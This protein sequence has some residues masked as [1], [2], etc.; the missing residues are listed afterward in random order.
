MG[1]F[2]TTPALNPTN[3]IIDQEARRVEKAQRRAAERISNRVESH[4]AEIDISWTLLRLRSIGG[5]AA[6]EVIADIAKK[7]LYPEELKEAINALAALEAGRKIYDIVV[8][9][10][11]RNAEIVNYAIAA[12]GG[13]S[14]RHIY[15]FSTSSGYVTPC[16]ELSRFAEMNA[17]AGAPQSIALLKGMDFSL[18]GEFLCNIAKKFPERHGSEIIEHLAAN[19]AH[20]LI[21][22]LCLE[23]TSL[24]E[25]GLKALKDMKYSIDI[26]M[27]AVNNKTLAE[28]AVNALKEMGDRGADEI[29]EIGKSHADLAA[30]ILAAL[31][32]MNAAN[33]IQRLVE[34]LLPEDGTMREISGLRE[35][36]ENIDKTDVLQG[37]KLV[38]L[39]DAAA[40]IKEDQNAYTDQRREIFDRQTQTV[41]GGPGGGLQIF[42]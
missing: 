3:R 20:E 13:I 26:R 37:T 22:E 7:L 27:I 17:G 6:A 8:S 21:R 10:R 30:M 39:F 38:P 36:F 2:S 24:A 29:V 33:E 16:E 15:N 9:H 32:E 25:P 11:L 42:G 41:P 35:A 5:P 14:P 28:G 1:L 31:V 19:D 4:W 40:K 23:H 18:A 12:L 34:M